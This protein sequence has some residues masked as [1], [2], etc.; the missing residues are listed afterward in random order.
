AVK[1]STDVSTLYVKPHAVPESA[2]IQA[3]GKWYPV[4]MLDNTMTGV[5]AYFVL[6]V[7]SKYENSNIAINTLGETVFAIRLYGDDLFISGTKQGEH[8]LVYNLN[9]VV[10]ASMIGQDGST[11][12]NI[13]HLLSGSYIVKTDSGVLKFIK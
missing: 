3:D 13:E 8:V 12:L 7:N 4:D 11:T 10:V 1:H 2:T 9:G 6:W 5:G